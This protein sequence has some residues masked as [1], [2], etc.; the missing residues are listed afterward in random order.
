LTSALASFDAV[1]RSF[2]SLHQDATARTRFAVLTGA[3]NDVLRIAVVRDPKAT[4]A[5]MNLHARPSDKSIDGVTA[6]CDLDRL[7]SPANL[8]PL[9]KAR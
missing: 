9:A 8:V 7:A 2:Q 1:R 3:K 5:A 6:K 4:A